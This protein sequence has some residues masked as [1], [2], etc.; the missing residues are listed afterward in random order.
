MIT[1][2]SNTFDNS[3]GFKGLVVFDNE[4][5]EHNERYTTNTTKEIS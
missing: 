1:F 5:G 3:A 4:A 2:T